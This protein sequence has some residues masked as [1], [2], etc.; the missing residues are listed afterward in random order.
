[1]LL[2]IVFLFS[3]VNSA[4][5][6]DFSF[7]SPS[8][9]LNV[10]DISAAFQ[11]SGSDLVVYARLASF[12]YFGFLYSSQMSKVQLC[13]IQGD[14]TIIEI[15]TSPLDITAADYIS[16]GGHDAPQCPTQPTT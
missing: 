6:G 11:V 12:G 16:P 1:M 7:P 15:T 10:S 4:S 13:L 3:F 2:S 9:A 8:T 14:Y 5:F